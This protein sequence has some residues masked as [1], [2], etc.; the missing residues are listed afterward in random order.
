M[1]IQLL[2]KVVAIALSQQDFPTFDS[3]NSGWPAKALTLLRGQP[4]LTYDF[5]WNWL[6]EQQWTSRMQYWQQE[7]K[8]KTIQADVCHKRIA[9][10]QF[11]ESQLG[12]IQKDADERAVWKNNR[13]SPDYFSSLRY[14]DWEKYLTK[15]LINYGVSVSFNPVNQVVFFQS[16]KDGNFNSCLDVLLE[17]LLTIFPR[18]VAYYV[19]G[20]QVQYTGEVDKI[21]N[22]IKGVIDGKKPIIGGTNEKVGRFPEGTGHSANEAMSKGLVASHAYAILGYNQYSNGLITVNIY[23]PWGTYFRQYLDNVYSAYYK[24]PLQ[25]QYNAADFNLRKKEYFDL[26]LKQ[27]KLKNKEAAI[28]L[29]KTDVDKNIPNF[30]G[31]K[32]EE[33]LLQNVSLSLDTELNSINSAIASLQI[34][35]AKSNYEEAKNTYNSEI[36][37]PD[38]GTSTIEL[39]DFVKRFR[40]I[41]YEA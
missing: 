5:N 13:I 34:S 33:K 20:Q 37:K 2:E 41:A 7:L 24:E 38:F 26:L 16:T 8:D 15:T 21:F 4:A 9:I 10:L 28:Q 19:K 1:E 29:N 17:E 11:I 6:I 32:N 22:I 31:S 14:E 25:I 39:S 18:K 12:S 35:N 40:H 23:N 36:A 27:E 30:S 3:I